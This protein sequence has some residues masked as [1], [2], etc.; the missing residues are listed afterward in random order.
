M[1]Q[2]DALSRRPDHITDKI[3][4]D[5]IIVLPNNIFIKM[6]NLELQ[7]EIREETAKDDFFVKALLAMKENGPLSIRS[8]LEDWKT[9]E[10]LLF[11]KNRCYIPLHE[12]LHQK[13]V[14]QYHDFLTGGHPGHFKTLELIR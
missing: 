13:I 1:I 11:F 12:K 10:G 7:N 5:D 2:S 6:V 8:K 14:K 3:D 4:N 9:E